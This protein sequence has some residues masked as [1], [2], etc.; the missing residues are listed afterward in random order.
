[1]TVHGLLIA[2]I[3]WDELYCRDL[4]IKKENSL[5][6]RKY[7][8]GCK[9]RLLFLLLQFFTAVGFG[10]GCDWFEIILPLLDPKLDPVKIKFTK[11]LN[12]SDIKNW[13]L[14]QIIYLKFLWFSLLLD[15]NML[16]KRVHVKIQLL[17]W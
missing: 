12:N 4:K 5:I 1:M 17:V 3:H 10:S 6:S 8:D 2:V 11:K 7:L 13:V 15:K 14:E 16:E 9:F